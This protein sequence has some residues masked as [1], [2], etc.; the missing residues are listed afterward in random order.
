MRRKKTLEN[1]RKIGFFSTFLPFNFYEI[2][3]L[4]H[5]CLNQIAEQDVAAILALNSTLTYYCITFYFIKWVSSRPL[6]NPSSSSEAHTHT[7]VKH[8]CSYVC[9]AF[10]IPSNC[11][12]GALCL[13]WDAPRCKSAKLCECEVGHLVKKNRPAEWI[14]AGQTAFNK[15]QIKLSRETSVAQQIT[16]QE[17]SIA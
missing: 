5:G 17:L 7:P 8:L 4:K 14:F 11:S 3:F 15:S 16:W 2:S 1:V 12:R 10:G 9:A 6:L 13:H